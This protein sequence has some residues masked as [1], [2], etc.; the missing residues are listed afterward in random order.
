MRPI[1]SSLLVFFFLHFVAEFVMMS[2]GECMPLIPLLGGRC[3]KCYVRQIKRKSQWHSSDFSGVA[4]FDEALNSWW[5]CGPLFDIVHRIAIKSKK[6]NRWI[7]MHSFEILWMHRFPLATDCGD[8]VPPDFVLIELNMS[9]G[10][11]QLISICLTS[12]F[13]CSPTFFCSI[14]FFI[15]IVWRAH[16]QTYFKCLFCRSM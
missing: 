9:D 11:A 4:A 8:E 2:N 13:S 14:L 1:V 7:R 12:L 5:C 10:F 6:K 15:R 3:S 16:H